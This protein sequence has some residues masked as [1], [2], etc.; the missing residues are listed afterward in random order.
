MIIK[1]IE[2]N[3]GIGVLVAEI[4][5]A[6]QSIVELSQRQSVLIEHALLVH[7]SVSYFS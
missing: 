7:R 2:G 5:K 4:V 1:L 6:A 3:Q